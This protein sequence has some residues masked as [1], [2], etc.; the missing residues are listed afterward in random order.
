MAEIHVIQVTVGPLISVVPG[1]YCTCRTWNMK[2]CENLENP[3]KP[4]ISHGI[5]VASVGLLTCRPTFFVWVCTFEAVSASPIT[6]QL[7]RVSTRLCMRL[8][9]WYGLSL[10]NHTSAYSCIYWTYVCSFDAVKALPITFLYVCWTYVHGCM[11]YAIQALLI[12][13]QVTVISVGVVLEVVQLL[14]KPRKKCFG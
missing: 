10:A 5:P 1:F 12:M 8:Y 7:T 14:F 3:G 11:S 2:V 9:V 13:L 6:H 4:E